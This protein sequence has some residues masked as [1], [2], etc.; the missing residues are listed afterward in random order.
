MLKIEM[1]TPA[2]LVRDYALHEIIEPARRRGDK[3]VRIVA[4]DVHK[5]L[6]FTNRAP[7]V[8]RTL[9]SKSFLE[10]NHLRLVSREGPPSGLS[11]RAVFTY[12]LDEDSATDGRL[13]A[14]LRYRGIAKEVFQSLGGG[15]AFIKSERE[16]FDASVAKDKA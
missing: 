7:L 11:T 4:G 8:C 5:A 13:A 1:K 9:A 6:G 2:D 14:F 10:Q 3:I 16:E 15:E 12:R